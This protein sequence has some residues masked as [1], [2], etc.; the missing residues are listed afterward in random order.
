MFGLPLNLEKARRV[1]GSVNFDRNL[2]QKNVQI[3]IQDMKFKK[4]VKT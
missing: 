3:E 1:H 4:T 2:G